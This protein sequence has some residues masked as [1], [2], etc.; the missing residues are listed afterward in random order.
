MS[1]GGGRGKAT[2]AALFFHRGRRPPHHSSLTLSE[3]FHLA[4]T[5]FYFS[6]AEITVLV[7]SK[8]QVHPVCKLGKQHGCALRTPAYIKI[9]LGII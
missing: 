3:S 2:R 9:E 5:I 7:S 1:A 6:G 4:E 8:L